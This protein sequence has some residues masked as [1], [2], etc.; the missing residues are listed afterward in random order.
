MELTT[1]LSYGTLR[2]GFHNHYLLYSS[3]FIGEGTLLRK[4]T[5]YVTMGGGFPILSFS[6]SS[7][8]TITVEAY[9]VNKLTL[10]NLDRLE[11]YP[12]WY[13]RTEEEVMLKNGTIIKGW[14]YH[15]DEQEGLQVVESGDWALYS[16]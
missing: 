16:N 6:P 14:I 9:K 11:G 4:G 7:S 3:Q 13:T 10:S 12:N 5:M 8:H 1:V 2:K 15:Q